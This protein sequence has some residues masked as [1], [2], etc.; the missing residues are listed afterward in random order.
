MYPS[1]MDSK[2]EGLLDLKPN[3][4]FRYASEWDPREPGHTKGGYLEG[5]LNLPTNLGDLRVVFST[6]ADTPLNLGQDIIQRYPESPEIHPTLLYVVRKGKGNRRMN[7]REPVPNHYHWRQEIHVVDRCVS[8][9]NSTSDAD[10]KRYGKMEEIPEMDEMFMLGNDMALNIGKGYNEL[11]LIILIPKTEARSFEDEVTI[12]KIIADRMPDLEVAE[13]ILLNYKKKTSTNIKKLKIKVEIFS[14]ESSLLLCSGLSTAICDSASKEHGALDFALASPLRSCSKGGRKV[15]MVA[16]GQIAKDVEPKFMLYKQNGGRL[17]EM[18]HILIQ[19]NKVTV[20]KETIVF[21]TPEQPNIEMIMKNGWTIKLAGVRKSDGFES[22]NKFN[23]NYVPDDFY[24]PCIF[25]ELKPDGNSGIAIL[26]SPIGPARPGVK[27]RRMPED[28]NEKEQEKTKQRITT[29]FPKSSESKF[30]IGKLHSF[31]E[32]SAHN[33]PALDKLLGSSLSSSSHSVQNSF[34]LKPISTLQRT[35]T[36]AQADDL[37]SDV[38]RNIPPLLLKRPFATMPGLIDLKQLKSLHTKRH[39]QAHL[40]ASHNKKEK[41]EKDKQE[42]FREALKKIVNNQKP[43]P[44]MLEK[45]LLKPNTKNEEESGI[46][47][48]VKLEE[49]ISTSQY[50]YS[51]F[52]KEKKKN[53]D[54]S[55]NIL[56]AEVNDPYVIKLEP[57]EERMEPETTRPDLTPKSAQEIPSKSRSLLNLLPL[58]SPDTT[59]KDQAT[60]PPVA[61]PRQTLEALLKNLPNSGKLCNF[62]K[63]H[64]P[65]QDIQRRKLTF[66][67]LK[68]RLAHQTSLSSS[69]IEM[70]QHQLSP[71]FHSELDNLNDLDILDK[72]FEPLPSSLND[73]LQT[74]YN[75]ASIGK[76]IL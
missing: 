47:F 68:S 66:P 37:M 59:W 73:S 11:N 51:S 31:E 41:Y 32:S 61:V 64:M 45:L 74:N 76:K 55:N 35:Y 70:I 18:D 12:N 34:K 71:K 30:L 13:S 19:P 39:K 21:I 54:E 36:T 75:Y 8:I 72:I 14:L 9:K 42:L 43:I 22:L 52:Q 24:D 48:V 25:C 16:E 28:I 67:G 27:K 49:N 10:L 57:E 63:K 62:P 23:F 4:L 7:E 1:S 15:L 56:H 3:H 29:E 44:T 65:T 17:E 40:S 2:T 53:I 20:L 33:L 5:R 46:P 26:P 60:K 69:N 50:L 58:E 6:V 38:E